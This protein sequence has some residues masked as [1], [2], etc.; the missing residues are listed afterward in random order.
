M[1]CV[2]IHVMMSEDVE[3]VYLLYPT[4]ESTCA[5]IALNDAFTWNAYTL[6]YRWYTCSTY[7]LLFF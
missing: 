7:S 5:C 6:C 2:R 1:Q 3:C 4:H